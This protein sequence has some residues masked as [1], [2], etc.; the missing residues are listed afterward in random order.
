MDTQDVIAEQIQHQM[1][2]LYMEQ[3]NPLSR[4]LTTTTSFALHVDSRM[5]SMFMMGFRAGLA[6]GTINEE[7]ARVIVE[8]LQHR[9]NAP[10]YLT[11]TIMLQ[12]LL[13]ENSWRQTIAIPQKN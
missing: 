6:L 3:M 4:E 2:K 13:G 10:G 8:A 7:L 9:T 12:T 1:Y 11:E 5:C